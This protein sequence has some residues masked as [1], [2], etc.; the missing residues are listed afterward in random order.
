[1]VMIGDGFKGLAYLSSAYWEMGMGILG[2]A[3]Q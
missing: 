1:M 2:G 3:S